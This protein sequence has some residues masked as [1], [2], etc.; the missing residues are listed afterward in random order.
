MKKY[1][2]NL[3]EKFQDVNFRVFALI[4]QY[5]SVAWNLPNHENP[6]KSSFAKSNPCTRIGSSRFASWNSA[7]GPRRSPDFQECN[8]EGPGTKF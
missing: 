6:A 1:C 2:E 8:K 3:G 4:G 5:L 7:R